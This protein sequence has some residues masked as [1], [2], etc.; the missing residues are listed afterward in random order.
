MEEGLMKGL[1]TNMQ[2]SLGESNKGGLVPY[3]FSLLGLVGRWGGGFQN[4]ERRAVETGQEVTFCRRH[5]QYTVTQ[6]EESW[7]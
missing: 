4:E 7:E 3:M 2:G 5:T 1:C 6:L